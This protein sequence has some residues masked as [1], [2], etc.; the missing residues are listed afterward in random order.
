MHAGCSVR[1]FE[2]GS[3]ACV[4][5]SLLCNGVNDCRDAGDEAFCPGNVPGK[6]AGYMCSD[7]SYCIELKQACEGFKE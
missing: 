6:C 4:S 7:L 2:C 5:Q 1:E 3:G